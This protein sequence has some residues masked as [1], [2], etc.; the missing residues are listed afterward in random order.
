[1]S[2]RGEAY[3]AEKMAADQAAATRR[4]RVKEFVAENDPE[5][6]SDLFTV[7][8]DAVIEN[9]IKKSADVMEQHRI[10]TAAVF[11]VECEFLGLL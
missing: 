3:F 9:G 7:I 2:K 10:A 8:K 5:I 11:D 4:A 6:I 1:M